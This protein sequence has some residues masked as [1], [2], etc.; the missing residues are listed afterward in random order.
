M[1]L[2][3]L[4]WKSRHINSLAMEGKAVSE[5]SGINSTLTWLERMDRILSTQTLVISNISLH[6]SSS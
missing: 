1:L 3:A 5:T 4:L 6:Y 2:T